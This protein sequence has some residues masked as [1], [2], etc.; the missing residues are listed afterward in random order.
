VE[1]MSAQQQSPSLVAAPRSPFT[2]LVGD[3]FEPA[4]ALA[5]EQAVGL[6]LRI[7]R[8]HLHVVHV[9]R[10]DTTETDIHRLTAM[11]RVYIEEKCSAGAPLDQWVEIHVRRGEPVREIVRLATD[12]TASIILVGTGRRRMHVRELLQGSLGTRL[13]RLAPCPVLIAE[14]KGEPTASLGARPDRV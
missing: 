11:L 10:D 6:A 1:T 14:P 3:D 4:S 7:P 5:F 8:S 2:I 12:V 9:V 13:A